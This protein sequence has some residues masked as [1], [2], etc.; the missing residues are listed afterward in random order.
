MYP[1][2]ILYSLTS[3]IIKYI[4]ITNFLKLTAMDYT[5]FVIM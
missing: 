1:F 3:K 2:V 5:Y 4:L